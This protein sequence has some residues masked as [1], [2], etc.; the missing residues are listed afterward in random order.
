VRN[1]FSANEQALEVDGSF[2]NQADAQRGGLPT[3]PSC[4]PSLPGNSRVSMPTPDL[5]GMAEIAAPHS[6]VGPAI[7]P[8][9][10][11]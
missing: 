1:I 8:I 11:R 3:A 10:G 9:T 5:E 6:A 7:W 2:A 4:N